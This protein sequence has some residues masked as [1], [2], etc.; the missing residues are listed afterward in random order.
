MVYRIHR[1][2]ASYYGILVH[3]TRPVN[4]GIS[5]TISI[6]TFTVSFTRHRDIVADTTA[7]LLLTL[8]TPLAF[9]LLLSLSSSLAPIIRL[10]AHPFR[11]PTFC[12]I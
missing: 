4:G 1:T 3:A 2:S 9:F 8:R 11:T 12:F 10:V 7:A 6:A 5:F